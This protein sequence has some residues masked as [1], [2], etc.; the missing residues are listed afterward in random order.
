MQKLF[1]SLAGMLLLGTL[2]V[3]CNDQP[4]EAATTTTTSPDP[5]SV[6]SSWKLGVQLWTFHKFPFY[7]AIEKADSAGIKFIEAYPSQQLSADSKEAFGIQMTAESKAKVKQLLQSKG[8]TLV[9][10]GVTSPA[11][12]EEWKQTFEFAKEMGIQYLTSEPKQQFWGLAD[13]L[14]GVYG[15]RIAIHDHPYPSP[16]A[17]PDS[18]IAAMKGHPNI[19]ACADLGHWARNGLDVVECL[20]KLEGRIIGSHLKDITE[21]NNTKSPDT[22]PGKGVIKFPEVFAEF[23]RQGFKGMFSIEHESNW[24]NNVPDVMQIV[25]YYNEQVAQLK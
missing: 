21:F 23:K 4:K 10:L 9:A 16:F 3:Q 7:T 19:Y 5:T 24:D 18:V 22:I 2:F 20:K 25:K 13:S 11:T 1:A 8:M 14:A 15:I 12:P 6:T 17:H